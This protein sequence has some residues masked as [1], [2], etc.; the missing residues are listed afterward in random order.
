MITQGYQDLV[1]G[2]SIIFKQVFPYDS[3]LEVITVLLRARKCICSKNLRVVL[4][5]Q[6]EALGLSEH[7]EWTVLLGK[8]GCGGLLRKGVWR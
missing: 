2:F 7:G 3:P 4:T 1:S 5:G 8:L 6:S